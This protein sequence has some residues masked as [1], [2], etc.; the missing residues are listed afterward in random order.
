MKK[1][2][3]SIV[4]IGLLAALPLAGQENPPA[5]QTAEKPTLNPAAPYS[6]NPMGRRD[7]FKDLLGGANIKEKTGTTEISV[8]DLIL[9]GIIKNKKGFTAIVGTNQGFPDFVNVG[10]K[11]S[12]GYVLRITENQIV[13]RKTHD[14]G[15]PLMR[16]RDIVREINPEER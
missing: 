1:L 3:M 9:I 4:V 7:P 2:I 6:F 13:F 8:E 15:L 12:D 10:D 16:P 14:R 5:A 11:F